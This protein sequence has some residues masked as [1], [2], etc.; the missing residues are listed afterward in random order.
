MAKNLQ[1]GQMVYV[2]SMLVPDGER[3]PH[4]IFRAEVAEI[5]NRSV[6]VK[7]AG[8]EISAPIASSKI[9]SDLGI[10]IVSIGDFATEDGLINPLTKSVLQFCRL[11]VPDDQLTTVR[12]RAIGELGSWW[13]KNHA[14]YTLIILIGHGSSTAI[15]FGVGGERKPSSFDRRFRAANAEPKTFISLCCETGR[16]PFAKEFSALPFCGALIAPFHSVHGAV[17]SQFV[18]SFLSLNLLQAKSVTVAYKNA[19]ESVPGRERF[20]LWRNG[21]HIR[22]ARAQSNETD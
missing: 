18:Q 10:A 9:L 17:A 11:L 22:N 2:P 16:A 5:I 6:R 7:I 13:E 4:S 19:V 8:G 14:V 20:R 1:V 21:M 15:T 3:L 12:I